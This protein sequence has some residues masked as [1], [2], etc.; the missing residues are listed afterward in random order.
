MCF[1]AVSL[2]TILITTDVDSNQNQS[3]IE[4][5]SKIYGKLMDLIFK[6][7]HIGAEDLGLEYFNTTEFQFDKRLKEKLNSIKVVFKDI[8]N[9]G[10]I[11]TYDWNSVLEAT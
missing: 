8:T 1:A 10:V 7:D 11:R 5:T 2:R 6:V 4:K 3:Y 9:V